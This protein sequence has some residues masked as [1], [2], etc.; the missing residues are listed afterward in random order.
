MFLLLWHSADIAHTD[1]CKSYTTAFPPE[2][3][4]WGPAEGEK[5]AR[6]GGA[7]TKIPVLFPV[8]PPKHAQRRHRRIQTHLIENV[9]EC[10][11]WHQLR[12]R[13]GGV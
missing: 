1:N 5:R 6:L 2:G 4:V 7:K 10:L 9:Q 12:L 13:G 8:P 11:I 3:Q